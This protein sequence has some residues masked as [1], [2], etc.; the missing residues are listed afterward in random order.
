IKNE[1]FL[2]SVKVVEETIYDT[3]YKKIRR[4]DSDRNKELKVEVENLLHLIDSIP[5]DFSNRLNRPCMLEN[6]VKTKLVSF[7]DNSKVFLRPGNAVR[8]LLKSKK[9]IKQ[10]YL[11]NLKGNEEILIINN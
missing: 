2:P 4:I 6:A 7:T 3:L 11:K 8:Y 10:D 1:L 5:S 9:D